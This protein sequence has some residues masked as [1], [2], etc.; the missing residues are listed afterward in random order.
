MKAR[1]ETRYHCPSCKS[2]VDL[3]GSRRE[4]MHPNV[5]PSCGGDC[6]GSKWPLAVFK[7]HEHFWGDYSL[8]IREYGQ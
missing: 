5:C 6:P 3:V 2:I 1:Y 7:V 8:F 4:P